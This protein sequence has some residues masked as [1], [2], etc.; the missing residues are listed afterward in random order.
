MK[1]SI[2][3]KN[4]RSKIES[5]GLNCIFIDEDNK[6]NKLVELNIYK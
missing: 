4:D 6:D 3:D 2:F 5:L 1:K